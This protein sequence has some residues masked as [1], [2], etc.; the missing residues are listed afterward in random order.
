MEGRSYTRKELAQNHGR[1][2]AP[3]LIAYQGKVYD[4]SGNFQWQQG[5][6]WATHS[7]GQDL[8]GALSLAPHGEDLLKRLKLV[9]WLVEEEA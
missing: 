9:G 3:A 4:A 7:A 1:A 6:H 8:T 2:G 5:R